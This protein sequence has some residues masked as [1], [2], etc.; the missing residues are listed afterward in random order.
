MSGAA[1]FFSPEVMTATRARIV[2]YAKAAGLILTNFIKGSVPEQVLEAMTQTANTAAA[3]A[4]AVIRG[5]SSLDSST[6]PGD[7]DPYNPGRV[8]ETPGPGYLSEYGAGM[9]GTPRIGDDFANGTMTIT[10]GS[11]SAIYIAPE[12]VTFA[13]TLDAAVTYRNEA[14]ASIYTNPDGTATIAAGDTLDVP[15]VCEIQ[16]TDGNAGAGAV[17]LVTTLGTSVTATN[18]AVIVAQEREAADPYRARCRTAAALL[19]LN[20]PADAYRFICLGAYK[21][22]DDNIFFFPPFGDGTTAIGVDADGNFA[23]FPNARGTSIGITGV[24]V[25]EDNT[26]GTVDVWLRSAAGDPGAQALTDITALLDEVYLPQCNQISYHR[27]TNVTFDITAAIRV[28]AG[29]GITTA[30]IEDGADEALAEAF[31]S[32]DIGGFDRTLGS[33]TIYKE[34][35]GSTINGSHRNIY[36]VDVTVPAGNTALAL[37]EVAVLGTTSYTTVIV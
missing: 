8:N 30:I 20:G 4:S 1:D 28:R 13:K 26:D 17:E 25:A 35:I 24:Y 2:G 33:G 11:G 5:R 32:W 15:L 29:A 9:Y 36:R 7:P 12:T 3:I 31:Q 23:I 18:A 6:D 34:E 27:A 14:D 22:E 16:G 19:S 21:D 37:G 10:N